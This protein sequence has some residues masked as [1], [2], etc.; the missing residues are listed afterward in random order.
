MFTDLLASVY[1]H[2]LLLSAVFTDF[3]RLKHMT[4]LYKISIFNFVSMQETLEE[5]MRDIWELLVVIY[6]LAA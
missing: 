3:V 4:V 1:L 2:M 6:A 5:G